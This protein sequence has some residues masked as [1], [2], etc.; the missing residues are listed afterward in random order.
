MDNIWHKMAVE[1]QWHINDEIGPDGTP[2]ARQRITWSGLMLTEWAECE[3]E[4][5]NRVWSIVD[6]KPEGVISELVDIWIRGADTLGACGEPIEGQALIRIVPEFTTNT[7]YYIAKSIEVCR[8]GDWSSYA[9]W[10]RGAMR[11]SQFNFR[12]QVALMERTITWEDA[13]RIKTEYNATRTARHGG[14]LA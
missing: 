13:L 11:Q 5:G 10:I 3:E 6:G 1:K 4:V 8:T 7:C 2:S 9:G 14:K 12:C